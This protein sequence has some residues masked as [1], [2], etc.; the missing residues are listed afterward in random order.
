MLISISA[1]GQSYSYSFNG[2][3]DIEDINAIEKECAQLTEVKWA[4]C[5]YK[6]DRMAGELLIEIKPVEMEDHREDKS[7]FSP[8]EVKML[9]IA[10]NLEPLDFRSIKK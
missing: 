3:L 6:S 1:Y 7:Q 10:R 8:I 9:L 5:R 4:K 2:E